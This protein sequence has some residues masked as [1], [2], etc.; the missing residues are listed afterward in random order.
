MGKIVAAYAR[1][2]TERQAE[3]QTIEQQVA[4]LRAY[5]RERGWD[6]TDAQLYRDDGW[7][8][9]RL[10]RPG[11]GAPW[12]G[13]RDAVARAAADVLL[14][15]S[16]DRLARRYAYQ[17]WLLEE[18]ARAGCAV[19]FLE[20]PPSDDPQDA[21][22]SQIRGAVA[23]YERTVIADRTRRGRLAKLRAGQLLPWSTPPYGYRLDP[24]APRGPTTLRV[25][26]AQAA[27]V[28]QIFAWYVEDGLT[29]YAVAQ[30]L[31][32]AHTPTAKDLA[33]RNASSVRAI[34][35][36]SSYQG[37][38]YGNKERQDPARR[39]HPLSRREVT[40]TGGYTCE[41]RPAADW[42]A[43]PVPALITGEDFAL[44]QARLARNPAWSRR[45]ARQ[46]YLLRRLVSC[47][48]CG[49]AQPI[50]NNGRRAVYRCPTQDTAVNRRR[51]TPC[52]T[53]AIPAAARDAAVW[54]DLCQVL[55][56]LAI[57]DEAMRRAQAG[58]LNDD[59][60]AA[61]GHD[62]R[63]RRATLERQRQR[64]IDAYA[65][66][67][68]TLEE[69][70]ARVQALDARLRDVAQEAQ[71]L[72]ASE[73]HRA[74]VAALAAQLEAF[75]ATIAAGLDHA[76]F[77]RRRELVELLIDRVLVDPPEVEI[78][79]LTPFGGSVQRKVALRLRHQ[80]PTSWT[81]IARDPGTCSTV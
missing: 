58:W 6:L 68:V 46:D 43:I 12:A 14:V 56:D 42:I 66:G 65:V 59:V 37:T 60:R 1:V 51:P 75:R 38:A 27:V 20:R 50:I 45:N 61:R 31:T 55:S 47:R 52:P 33:R 79:Y 78:R 10:D 53:P 44:A 41:P 2:S 24:R 3:R 9:A 54:A 63:R 4:A 71:Q 30:R 16:P 40:G 13:L 36:N 74:Q 18:F 21:L 48:R 76:S 70:Q 67:A 57:L 8:G 22:V 5:A 64:L 49:M 11:P 15:V 19:L 77:A 39:R 23:E 69:L 81:H 34:L 26:E 73:E 32:A 80:E 35:R 29:L 28:R 17:V 25:D 72:A 62:L 7:S